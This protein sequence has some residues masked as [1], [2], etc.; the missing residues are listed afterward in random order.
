MKLLAMLPLGVF[1]VGWAVLLAAGGEPRPDTSQLS[2]RIPLPPQKREFT[3]PSGNYVFVVSNAD[4]WRSNQ[5]AGELLAVSGA[6][7]G[8]ARRSLWS[9]VLPQGF[10]PRFVLL[11]DRGQVLLLDEWINIKSRHAAVL[12]NRENEVV[13]QHDFDAVQAVLQIPAAEIVRRSKHGWWIAAPPSLEPSGEVVRVETA[14]KTLL[15]G[16]ADGQLSLLD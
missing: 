2:D 4:Q 13:V 7:S 6:A 15:I 5:T 16:L 9:R 8:E 3:S 14:G 10:G 12:L 1:F 11:N